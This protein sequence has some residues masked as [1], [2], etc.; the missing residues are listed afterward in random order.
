MFESELCH[1]LGTFSPTFFIQS[2]NLLWLSSSTTRQCC[3]LRPLASIKPTQRD[4]PLL[5]VES[6]PPDKIHVKKP[7]ADDDG[8]RGRHIGR[9]F[10]SWDQRPAS[11]D[12]GRTWTSVRRDSQKRHAGELAGR[13]GN[14]I[15]F[16]SRWSSL[17]EIKENIL[18]VL[19]IIN[20][21]SQMCSISL[22]LYTTVYYSLFKRKRGIYTV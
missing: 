12:T 19:G 10:F 14:Y 7:A 18:Y 17:F 4:L 1:W 20:L 3:Y 13:R 21:S 16:Y 11:V 8:G 6:R 22:S 15:L 5:P 9:L 2:M